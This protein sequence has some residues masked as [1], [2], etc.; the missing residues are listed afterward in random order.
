MRKLTGWNE[1]AVVGRKEGPA[2]GNPG[3]SWLR[4]PNHFAVVEEDIG[5]DI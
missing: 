1:D 5:M 2:Q 4:A 3:G